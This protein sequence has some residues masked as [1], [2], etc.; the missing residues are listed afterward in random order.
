MAAGIVVRALSGGYLVDAGDGPVACGARGRLRHEGIRPV[1]GD[2]A[3]ITLLGDGTG[4]L[5]R[6]LARKNLFSRPAVAN[7][8]CLIIVASAAPPV[9]DLFTIDKLTAAAVLNGVQPVVCLNKIDVAPPDAIAQ[10]YLLAD[11]PVFAVSAVTKEG[12]RA[13]SDAVKGRVCAFAGASGVGKSSLIN[14][15]CPALELKTGDLSDRLGRGKHTT[16][17]VELFKLENGAFI[18]DTP[19]FTALE[20]EAQALAGRGQIARAFPEFLRFETACR[21]NGCA[22]MKD[23]GCAVREAVK[24]GE[25]GASRYESYKRLY[26]QAPK[27][28]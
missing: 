27:P 1:V 22:H 12:I 14:A 10:V 13:L 8:D 28:Y 21:F 17:H 4:R 15:L 3:E 2:R 24:R 5:E 16:R 7:I 23:S 19:G 25:I 9:S 18:V 11:I 20:L 6:V 26:E